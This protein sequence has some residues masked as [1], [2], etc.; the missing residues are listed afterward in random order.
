MREGLRPKV[1]RVDWLIR[2]GRL[3]RFSPIA[4]LSKELEVK[5]LTLW[6]GYV[7]GPTPGIA[8]ALDLLISAVKPES[9]LDLFCGSGALSKLAYFRGV[10]RVFS[11]DLYVE[12]AERNLEG[13]RGVE[14]LEADALSFRSPE[15]FDLLVADSPEE[16]IDAFVSDVGRIRRLFKAAALIWLGPYHRA[17]HRVKAFKRTRMATAFEAWGDG[18]AILWKPGLKDKV[19]RVVKLLA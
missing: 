16:L 6:G 11:V 10:K 5:W 12:A 7:Y 13:C 15:K 17:E 2:S 18:L 1:V 8:E 19:E 14:V 4:L 3:S 9:M